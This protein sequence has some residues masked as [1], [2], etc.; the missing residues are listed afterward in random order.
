[1]EISSVQNFYRMQNTQTLN[2]VKR[3]AEET[4]QTAAQTYGTDTVD[5]SADASFRATLAASARSYAAQ[6]M[7]NAS[8][9]RL[10]ALRK[11]YAGDNVPVSGRDIAASVMRS[12]F[13]TAVE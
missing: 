4:A 13:G 8:P 7:Q 12:A 1:M 3:P 10:A 5:I 11:A 6:N 2:R 9:E